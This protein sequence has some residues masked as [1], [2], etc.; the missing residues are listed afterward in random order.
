MEMI[1]L[2]NKHGKSWEAPRLKALHNRAAMHELG[3]SGILVVAEDKL[4]IGLWLNR[5]QT[6]RITV[7]DEGDECRVGLIKY[8]KMVGQKTTTKSALSARDQGWGTGTLSPGGGGDAGDAAVAVA[9]A[10]ADPYG[11]LAGFIVKNSPLVKKQYV[12]AIT[13]GELGNLARVQDQEVILLARFSGGET[14]QLGELRKSFAPKIL[15]KPIDQ[16]KPYK[17]KSTLENI[18]LSSRYKKARGMKP[19]YKK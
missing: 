12:L 9:Q 8:K 10:V 18:L 2:K 14:F 19:G 1:Y 5:H 15:A 3:Q 16:V 11:A 6:H 17:E 7:I 4:D 13:L